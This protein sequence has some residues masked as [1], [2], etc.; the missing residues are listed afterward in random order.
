M[1][2]HAKK[3]TATAGPRGEGSRKVENKKHTQ[4]QLNQQRQK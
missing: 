4:V 2:K 3:K 1:Q